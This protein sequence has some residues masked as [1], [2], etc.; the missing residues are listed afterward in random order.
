MRRVQGFTLVE[1]LVVIAVIA[2]LASLLL[3]GLSSSREKA[4]RTSCLSQERQFVLAALLYANDNQQKLPVPGNENIDKTDTHTPIFSRESH[5]NLTHYVSALKTLDCP[6]LAKW[7]EQKTGWRM[8]DTFGYAIG[9]HY[10][11]G[12]L[13]TPWKPVAGSTNEWIS[14]QKADE[15][16]MLPLVADLNV[17]CYSFQRILAPH[18]AAGP[19]VR[20]EEY[21]GVND[22]ANRETPRDVGARGGNVGR[23]DGSAEWRAISK[24]RA[25][26]ASHLYGADGAFGYW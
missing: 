1:L 20:D 15:N 4:R 26:R 3:P 7:M 17:Y 18:T 22:N 5:T 9:Y 2:I 16:P 19:A 10:F 13:A 11:G 14:P 12:H 8:H 21:F 25:Y 6:N 24:M 23:L